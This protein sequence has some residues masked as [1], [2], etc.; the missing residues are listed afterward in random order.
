MSHSSS[1]SEFSKEYEQV[2][3][4]IDELLGGGA[5]D[6][7]EFSTDNNIGD[8]LSTMRLLIKER[9]REQEKSSPDFFQEHGSQ[10]GNYKIVREIGRGGMGLVFEAVELPLGRRVAIKILSLTAMHD[11]EKV[12]R[13]IR[14]AQAAARLEHPRIVRAYARGEDCGI[15]FLAMQYIDGPDLAKYIRE[16]QKLDNENPSADNATP[17]SPTSSSYFREISQIIQQAAEALHYAHERQVIHRDIKP[18]NLILD[19]DGNVHI[20]DFGL[21]TLEGSSRLTTTGSILGTLCYSSPEQTRSNARIDAR[22]DIYSL[23]V[24]LYEL[25]VLAPPFSDENPVVMMHNIQH[26]APVP[27]R[28]ITP[29]LPRELE[30]IILKAISKEPS[31]RYQTA[32]EFAADLG[33][34]L[35]NKPVLAK[36]STF[37]ERGNRWVRSNKKSILMQISITLL[38]VAG[39][40]GSVSLLFSS[41]EN[42]FVS[43]QTNLQLVS[44]TDQKQQFSNKSAD[45]VQRAR[46]QLYCSDL[47]NTM[48]LAEAG[49]YDAVQTRLARHI[50]QNG[51]KDLR[52]FVW[53][54][55][56]AKTKFK[57]K[58]LK[59]HKGEV[60]SMDMAS[61]LGVL[62][63]GDSFGT[64]VLWDTAT[65]RKKGELS[66]YFVVQSIKFSPDEKLLAVSGFDG[67]I[68]IYQTDTWKLL[69]TF[70]AHDMTVKSLVFNPDGKKLFSG[71]WEGDIACWSTE[72]WEEE[73]RFAAHD[74]VQHLS[75]SKDGR[76]L[77]SCGSDGLLRTWDASSGEMFF[78]VK[79][80][81]Q[82]LLRTAFSNDGS[83]VATGGGNHHVSVIDCRTGELV[84]RIYLVGTETRSIRFLPESRDKIMIGTNAGEIY[85][86]DIAIP[87]DPQIILNLKIHDRAINQIVLHRAFNKFI[88]ASSDTSVRIVNFPRFNMGKGI[89]VDRARRV[90]F[91]P[92]GNLFVIAH[93]KGKYAVYTRLGEK[94]ASFATADFDGERHDIGAPQVAF[95][96]DKKVWASNPVRNKVHISVSSLEPELR[97]E[98]KI[99]SFE[100]NVEGF[101]LSDDG[102]WAVSIDA[103]KQ[104][105]VWELPAWNEIYRL[106]VP[107]EKI[108]RVA[109]DRVNQVIA[110]VGDTGGAYL[111]RC[112]QGKLVELER[113]ASSQSYGLYSVCFNRLGSRVAAGGFGGRIYIWDTKTGRLKQEFHQQAEAHHQSTAI[114]DLAFTHD[115]KYLIS[116]CGLLGIWHIESGLFTIQLG[117]IYHDYHNYECLAV[118][119]S[120]DC[121]VAYGEQPY[122]GYLHIWNTRN[123]TPE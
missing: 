65:W 80:H 23:G 19:K 14:E 45:V 61:K 57:T 47:I 123:D 24:T 39:I 62:A 25:A 79:N 105:I 71:S 82:A 99:L 104:G 64:I 17:F 90:R 94:I 6:L 103:G 8:L 101:W 108:N 49:E 120:D 10:F 86:Y 41:R 12:A 38:I 5:P 18:S 100:Q 40:A 72:T 68:Q 30:S 50:P 69:R 107:S 15:F 3:K 43:N 117:P 54:Y 21:A 4:A 84:S 118:S 67:L 111:F 83:V 51:E 58:I 102:A 116:G 109:L 81:D 2:D 95:S 35:Q 115:E 78:E 11:E 106:K 92:D 42:Q 16:R 85:I 32:L 121:L 26:K 53:K 48:S 34:F 55:L 52:G 1:D 59:A 98:T 7:V 93:V 91:S 22:T 122:H 9:E 97:T 89:P 112:E 75:L 74:V 63:T 76:M 20:A 28:K 119:P 113:S 13:F 37:I 88:T 110:L 46:E 33:R 29:D 56:D 66:F 36:R 96:Q 31:D 44:S 77:A 70:R 114:F 27:P 73:N 87:G 60:L